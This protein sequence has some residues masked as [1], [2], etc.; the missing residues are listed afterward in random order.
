MFN[1]LT[2]LILHGGNEWDCL[3]A[4]W[5]L[6][7]CPC[8]YKAVL[9]NMMPLIN[10]LQLLQND[11]SS[12][13]LLDGSGLK[14]TPCINHPKTNKTFFWPM[15][16]LDHISSSMTTATR[17]KQTWHTMENTTHNNLEHLLIYLRVEPLCY[18]LIN[19][20]QVQDVDS[21]MGQQIDRLPPSSPPQVSDFNDKGAQYAHLGRCECH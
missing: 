4:P 19:L 16:I 3:H 6:P 15:S 17:S 18:Y 13:W 11:Q 9:T 1:M 14:V 7:W 12:H 10:I 21:E 20:H 2:G 8:S 5:L